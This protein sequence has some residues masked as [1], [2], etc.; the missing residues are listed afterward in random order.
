[1]GFAPPSSSEGRA[2]MIRALEAKRTRAGWSPTVMSGSLSTG[3]P[4]PRSVTRPPSTARSGATEEM[5]GRTM[6]ECSHFALYTLHFEAG[7]AFVEFHVPVEIVAPALGS[8]VQTNRDADGRSRVGPAR[9]PQQSH[10]SFAWRTAAL[11]PVTADA[12][13]DDVLPVLASAVS[14]RDHVVER[15]LRS[16][17]FLVAVLA[18]MMVARVDVRPR[19]RHVIELTLDSNEPKE[20][21]DRGQLDAERHRPYLAVVD[22]DHLDLPLAPERNRLLPVN[23]LERLVRRVQK[24]RLLHTAINDAGRS[25]GLS[26]F[27]HR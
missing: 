8:R 24:E 23:D 15:Q 22:R 19:E 7:S 14:H 21:D 17:E 3:K 16:R 2:M 26:R 10:A 25:A 11:L 20:A 12:T 9:R 1:M 5:V 27:R 13:G 18:R 6:A 4:C